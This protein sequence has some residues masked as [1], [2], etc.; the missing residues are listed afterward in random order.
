MDYVWHRLHDEHL[1]M[2][3]PFFTSRCPSNSRHFRRS[4]WTPRVPRWLYSKG[5]I[6]KAVAYR[7]HIMP[8]VMSLATS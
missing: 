8:T 5:R 3:C 1:V 6:D 2:A 7:R 4:I